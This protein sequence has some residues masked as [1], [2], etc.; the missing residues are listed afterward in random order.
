[1]DEKKRQDKTGIMGRAKLA[2]WGAMPVQPVSELP[3]RG[4]SIG[5]APSLTRAPQMLPA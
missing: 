3:G 1:M 2:G 4:R 5:L